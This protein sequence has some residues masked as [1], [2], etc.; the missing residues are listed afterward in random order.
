MNECYKCKFR[1]DLPGSAHSQCQAGLLTLGT[2]KVQVVANQHG[3]NKGWFM[4]PFD[5]DPVWLERCNVWDAMEFLK[6]EE[7]VQQ[8]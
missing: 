2:N 5:Y 8:I 4:W 7:N 3:I 1:T 6:G